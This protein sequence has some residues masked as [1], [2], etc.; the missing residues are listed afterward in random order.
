[1]NKTYTKYEI[2]NFEETLLKEIE[3]YFHTNPAVYSYFS[4][5]RKGEIKLNIMILQLL[6]HLLDENKELKN[7]LQESIKKGYINES[8]FKPERNCS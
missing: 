5:Y 2:E 4:M 6:I 1:V 3:Q 8:I 7:K